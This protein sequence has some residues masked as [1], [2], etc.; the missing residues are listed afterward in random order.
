MTPLMLTYV[1]CNYNG[2]HMD[3]YCSQGSNVPIEGLNDFLK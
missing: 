1:L 2:Q 3:E